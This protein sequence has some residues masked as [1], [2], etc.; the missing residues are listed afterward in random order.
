MHFKWLNKQGVES[1][2]GFS[3]QCTGRHSFEY[4]E[5]NKTILLSTDIG[6]SPSMKP[7]VLYSASQ[8]ERWSNSAEPI[9]SEKKHQLIA[10]FIAALQ[11]QQLEACNEL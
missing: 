10:N 7:A 11:F 9:S 8:F 6:F 3:V 1:D 2:T 5:G 4:R